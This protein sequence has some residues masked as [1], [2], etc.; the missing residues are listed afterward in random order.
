[1]E[2]GYP[3]WYTEEALNTYKKKYKTCDNLREQHELIATTLAKYSPYGF[4]LSFNKFFNILW[5]SWLSPA[6]PVYSVGSDSRILGVSCAG[7]YPHNSI[8]GFYKTYHEIAMLTKYGFGT[9][10]YLGGIDH[11][12]VIAPSGVLTDGTLNVMISANDAAQRVAQSGKRAGAVASYIDVEHK[13]FYEILTNSKEDRSINIGFNLSDNT[14]KSMF[15]GSREHKD[16]FNELCHMRYSH[17]RGYL[18]KIDTVNRQNPQA[19]INNG[20]KVSASNLCNEISLFSDPE[21]TFTCVL[22]SL[23]LAKYDEWEGT[24]TV[25]WSIVFLDCLVSYFLEKSN[26]KLGLENAIRFTEKSRA[27]GLGVTGWHT[28]FQDRMI[29]LESME[30]YLLNGKWFNDIKKQAVESSMKLAIHAGEPEWCKGTGM[31]NTHLLAVAPTLT[32]SSLMGGISEGINPFFGCFYSQRYSTS[33]VHKENPSFV[34]LC[35]NKGINIEFIKESIESHDGSI[36]HLYEFSQLEKDVFKNCAE[37]DQSVLIRMASVRQKYICQSQS[38]DLH[39]SEDTPKIVIAK[40]HKQLLLDPYIK[41][42][43]YLRTMKNIKYKEQKVCEA[44]Q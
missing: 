23:N 34:R 36:Q 15:T 4:D 41:G 44:C 22:S 40:H 2:K 24:D 13:D 33:L 28:Y 8:D 31:R 25:Y 11:R 1:M 35:K 27:L 9:S 12:G 7:S 14:I 16:I 18:H 21:H 6:S 37:I 38:L 19:Y 10:I 5:K 43:Y 42:A 30:A 29:P 17:G 3:D 39:Y 32:T 26:G 20:L